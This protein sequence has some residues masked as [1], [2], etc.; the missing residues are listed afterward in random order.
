MTALAVSVVVVCLAVGGLAAAAD[1]VVSALSLARARALADADTPGARALVAV[2]ASRTSTLPAL[3]FLRFVAQGVIVVEA[4]VVAVDHL[5]GGVRWLAVAAAVVAVHLLTEVVPRSL[6][7]HDAERNALRLAPVV[8][9]LVAVPPLRAVVGGLRRLAAVVVPGRARP[10]VVTEDELLALAEAAAAA[11]SIE[12]AESRLI[13]SALAF[14]DRVVREVMVPRPDMVTVDVDTT[15]SEAASVAI[16]HG[17]SRLPVTGDG[18]DDIVGLVLLKDLVRAERSGA[19]GAPLRSLMRRVRFVP[20]TKHTDEL[21]GEMRSTGQHL[22]VVVDEYGGTA[23][24]VTLEDLVEELVGEIVDEYDSEEPLMEP[25]A[26]GEVL[27]HGRMPVDQLR[28]LV[29]TDLPDGDWD[30]V[31]GLIFHTLGHVPVPGEEVEVEGLPM[32][33]EKVEGRRIT[34]VRLRRPGAGEGVAAASTPVPA[35]IPPVGAGPAGAAP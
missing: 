24:L 7:L 14:G 28:E 30:T 10:P 5:E 26:G 34:R 25:L 12:P 18:V 27:V 21:L 29:G 1:A 11:H 6:A 15:V 22:A 8:R 19:G 32:R 9:L 33:V 31:G 35:D 20:E 13:H 2:V 17:L 4:A 3:A 16:E 23:G